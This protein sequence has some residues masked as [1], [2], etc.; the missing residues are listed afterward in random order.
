MKKFNLV[1]A[2]L[3]ILSVSSV[4]AVDVSLSA[5]VSGEASVT[6][7]YDLDA[8]A[9]G[10]SNANSS[11]L[12]ITVVA[13]DSV[14]KGEGDVVGYIMIEN[15][16]AE[17]NG[18]DGVKI[19]TGSVTAKLM[20]GSLYIDIIGIDNTV[21]SASMGQGL[22]PD[23]FGD[24]LTG[25]A[26]YKRDPSDEYAG[27]GIG[28]DLGVASVEFGVTSQYD[29][30]ESD[31]SVAATY[32]W[33]PSPYTAGAGETVIGTVGTLDLVQTD[34]VADTVD[35]NVDNNYNFYGTVSVSAVEGLDLDISFNYEMATEAYGVG[36]STGYTLAMGDNSVVVKAGVDYFGDSS[37]ASVMEIGV[38]AGFQVAGDSLGDVDYFGWNGDNGYEI[39]PGINVGLRYDNIV[40]DADNN[41]YLGDL[42]LTAFDGDMIDGID[43]VA[44]VN[45]QN[46]LFG[47]TTAG[48]KDDYSSVNNL[49]I[50]YGVRAS[51]DLDMIS[52]Y[53]EYWANPENTDTSLLASSHLKIGADISVIDNTTFTLSYAS[54]DLSV[55]PAVQGVVEFTT[56]ISY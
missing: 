49:N 39:N 3:L 11:D 4:F 7:G 56:K 2:A 37:T 35:Q 20:L 31:A 53:L 10:F 42:M 22:V 54:G 23:V 34:A 44:F 41:I 12:V 28:T 14:E 21:N 24:S 38:G 6:F 43:L 33:E 5:E 30:V 25:A 40:I 36:A 13:E 47:S 45:V 16:S 1:I 19:D 52:P 29:W 26:G 27:I 51:A 48:T 17:L 18:S 50:Y 46:L 15:F 32:R 9:S 8:S 55:D